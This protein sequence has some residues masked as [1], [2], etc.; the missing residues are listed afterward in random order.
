MK[1][2]EERKAILE[3][4]VIKQQKKGWLI[5]SKTDTTAQMTKEVPPEGCLTIILF[6]TFIIPGILYL[7]LRKK[8]YTIYI[9]VNEEGKLKYSSQDLTSYQLKEAELMV[10]KI[11]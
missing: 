5:I 4:E 1:T 2:I 6:L 9:E 8:R 10:N 11:K 7:I 3:A